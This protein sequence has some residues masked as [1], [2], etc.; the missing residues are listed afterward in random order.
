[1]RQMHVAINGDMRL[2]SVYQKT[3]TMR[4]EP[5]VSNK[6]YGSGQIK[7][8]QWSVNNGNFRKTN[9]AYRIKSMDE[10]NTGD[11]F[12]AGSESINKAFITNQITRKS[13]LV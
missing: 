2:D 12:V 7:L 4:N 6:G 9:W 10:S 13:N 8:Y 1:M 11:L 3:V 5:M